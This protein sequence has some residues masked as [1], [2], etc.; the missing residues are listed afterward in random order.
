MMTEKNCDDSIDE[1]PD[2]NVF[3][4]MILLQWCTQIK[5]KFAFSGLFAQCA[6]PDR[7]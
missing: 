1:Y 5:M 2:T 7:D 4:M 6:S 3:G